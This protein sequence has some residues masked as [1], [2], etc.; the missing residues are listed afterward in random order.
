MGGLLF[1]RTLD[2]VLC[3]AGLC[4][5]D[6]SQ[7]T[8]AN[9]ATHPVDAGLEEV[10]MGLAAEGEY[11]SRRHAHRAAVE[12]MLEEVPSLCSSTSTAC[13]LLHI[14][15]YIYIYTGIAVRNCTVASCADASV[16]ARSVA[17]PHVVMWCDA[18]RRL[19]AR[20]PSFRCTPG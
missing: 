4:C 9:P 5:C 15:I 6:A 18:M 16:L 17:T 10:A 8:I 19:G 13:S 20:C 14:Y 1:T 7:I 11:E 2:A 12:Q 3:C